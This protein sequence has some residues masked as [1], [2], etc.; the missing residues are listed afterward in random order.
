MDLSSLGLIEAQ[1]L[2]ILPGRLETELSE[3]EKIVEEK[4]QLPEEYS[5]FELVYNET[6]AIC[7]SKNIN[8]HEAMQEEL[9]SI[10]SRILKYR[11]IQR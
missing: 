10:C 6:K 5:A 2:F 4:R 1:G 7:E 11:S 3:I 9:G 8:A